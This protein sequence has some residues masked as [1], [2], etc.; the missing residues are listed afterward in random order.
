MA[1]RTRRGVS[2]SRSLEVE[3][4][5]GGNFHPT[6]NTDPGPIA[7]KYREGKV[8]STLKRELKVPEVAGKEALGTSWVLQ[9]FCQEFEAQVTSLRH[10]GCCA[11]GFGNASRG[12]AL[13]A[14]CELG[15]AGRAIFS[16]PW[17]MKRRS[18]RASRGSKRRALANI[19]GETQR[20]AFKAPS[21]L[22][23]EARR[24]PIALKKRFRSTRLETRTK[25]S[26]ARSSFRRVTA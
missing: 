22:A 4:E 21:A 18:S 14:N 20:G 15:E 24:R 23:R 5:R 25:E 10:V 17:R 19:F 6:L 3:R 8:K 13:N 11:D 1:L 26:N 7:K 16:L 2:E 12:F 9:D